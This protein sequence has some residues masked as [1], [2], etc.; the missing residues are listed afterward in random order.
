MEDKKYIRDKRSPIPRS[1]KVSKVMSANK[2]KNSTPELLVRKLLRERGL[3]GYRLHPKNVIGKPDIVFKG[4]KLAVFIHGC[5][6]H[7]CPHCELSTPKHNSAFWQEKFRK[8]K[9]RDTK[10][11]T[12]LK[13]NG[14]NVV[15]I[16]ECKLK[17]NQHK[18]I[19]K[20]YRKYGSNRY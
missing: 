5:F 8:N 10:K 19:E 14:W 6:W 15:V 12:E 7:S 13:A 17:Q 20:I 3:T 9:Q 2:A 1:E 11:E 18:E 4:R 16:W